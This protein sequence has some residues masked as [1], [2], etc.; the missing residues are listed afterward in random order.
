MGI[1]QAES[2]QRVALARLPTHGAG[3][4]PWCS[5]VV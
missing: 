4:R 5:S 3:S 1:A 2:M